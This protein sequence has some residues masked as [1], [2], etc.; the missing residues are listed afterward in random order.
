MEEASVADGADPLTSVLERS[1]PQLGRKPE[2]GDEQR[3][4]GPGGEPSP[5]PSPSTPSSCSP[6]SPC[7]QPLPP[8]QHSP[9]GSAV[10]ALQSKVKALSE[11]RAAGRERDDRSP[12]GQVPGPGSG[13][14]Q[15][16]KRVSPCVFGSAATGKWQSSS[17]DEE[18]EP[19]SCA[20]P[21]LSNY[22]V[23]G[24]LEAQGEAARGDGC[25]AGPM[26]GLGS[27]S[28]ELGEGAS[29]ENLSDVSS[30]LPEEPP[31]SK[32]WA[33]PKGF[34]KATR[35]ET[36]LLNGDTL[37]A[38][39]RHSGGLTVGTAAQIKAWMV[40]GQGVRRELQR[41]DSLE[42]NLLRCGQTDSGLVAPLGGLWRADSWESVCSSG[43]SLSLAER[44]EMNRGLLKQML[45]K[46]TI[47]SRHRTEEA[48]DCKGR[49][50]MTVNDSD[51]DSGISL[52][53]SEH[54]Q[55]AFVFSDDLP[56]SPRHEQAKRLLERARMKARSYPLKADHT[57]LPVQ[58]D[59]P[60]PPSRASVP[61]RKA[62][63]AGKEGVAAASGN[64]SDSSSGDSVCGPRRRHGQ[65]PT[66]VRFE[67]ES[68]KDA[69]VRYLERLRQRR[70]AGERAQGLLVSKP[71]LSS[72][73]NGKK[74]GDITGTGEA[75]G[76]GPEGNPLGDK[77][78][79][80]NQERGAAVNG[81]THNKAAAQE[82]GSRKCNSCGTFLEGTSAA[83]FSPHS[84]CQG[85]QTASADQ[86]T[87]GKL[88]PCWVA[89]VPPNRTVRTEKIKETYIGEVTATVQESGL[90]YCSSVNDVGNGG[91]AERAA[92]LGKLKRKSRKGDGRQE[93]GPSPYA[94]MAA[95]GSC[96]GSMLPLE[97]S[98]GRLRHG[99]AELS[100]PH[101]TAALPPNPYVPNQSA[102]P[103][104]DGA[105][106]P[107]LAESSSH[108]LLKD[109]SPN[110]LPI[111]SALKSG[112]K[113]RPS[114]QRVVKL[115]P[116][117]EYRLIH[118]D[119]PE[120][121]CSLEP[122]LQPGAA[123]EQPG[124]PEGLHQNQCLEEK[125]SAALS[126]GEDSPSLIKPC[127]PGLSTSA[128][129]APCLKPSSLKYTQATAVE[130]W[131]PAMDEPGVSQYHQANGELCHDPV[132]T[133]SAPAPRCITDGRIRGPM[134]AEHL[135]EDSPDPTH[136]PDTI[137]RVAFEDS[138]LKE[139]KPKLSLRR[140]FS[141]IGLNSLG[142]HSK[143]RGHLLPSCGKPHQYRVFRPPRRRETDPVHTYPESSPA[144]QHRALSVE[145]VGSPSAVRSVGRV[146]QAFPDGTLLLEL[147][148]PPNG[149]FGFLISR[150]KGRPD[151]GVYVEEMGDRSTQKLYAGLLGV[152]DEIL[153]VNGEKVA[154]LSLDQVTRLMTQDCTASIRVLRHRRAQR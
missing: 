105:L 126:F 60:E 150:G 111:K 30:G 80:R 113:N 27:L 84:N 106:A 24:D 89:P 71:N 40:G 78:T 104:M 85:S 107:P 25:E 99:G 46:P 147:R 140:F 39:D 90:A 144:V 73:V 117:P 109:T 151:S 22:P 120:D 48:P 142:K 91:T 93:V 127:P 67:D 31:S 86:D 123:P 12:A 64:L 7:A 66:R 42:S 108:L 23:P 129:P 103:A 35:P 33:P 63:L 130:A 97:T 41:S 45:S 13:P 52:Q 16:M 20:H 3:Q 43:S 21:Y 50:L 134:R 116:S 68:E 70:R 44:V 119:T 154:G 29:L 15:A 8:L 135:R 83:H 37:L 81:G 38:G 51:W 28:R 55:R 49:G 132:S 59:N 137:K 141:A 65:S 143:G 79:R 77:K 87:Q 19:H 5:C 57:I 69:E 56:L 53:D 145:D 62:P 148:R 72:Y 1:E 58:K 102:S 146:A 139:G 88:M 152:G 11:R 34:W 118:L 121:Q 6:S 17:S 95:G 98:A 124:D 110:P 128:S 101:G 10:S 82:T 14:P 138:D 74:E 4:R 47:D 96:H 131:D 54:S 18:V 94:R 122:S 114:G 36:L 115:M 75:G 26:M 153:E 112:S 76:R 133:C 92:T 149:P 61:L 125:L 9:P 100:T 32:T 136:A 2:A